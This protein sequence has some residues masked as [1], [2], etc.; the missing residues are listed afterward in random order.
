MMKILLDDYSTGEEIGC[1]NIGSDDAIVSIT[2][3]SI[4]GRHA[5]YFVFEG[6]YNCWDW[7]K[8]NFEERSI[9]E[10]DGFVFH[11]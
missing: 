3:K 9:C 10:L 11:K 8:P 4:T 2:V 1:C 6:G 7:A 5:V